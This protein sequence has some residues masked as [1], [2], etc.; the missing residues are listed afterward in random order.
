[1]SAL[2]RRAAAALALALVAGLALVIAAP[3]VARADPIPVPSVPGC[4]TGDDCTQSP[5][6]TR[7]TWTA[8]PYL[9]P[10]PINPS[11]TPLPRPSGHPIPVPSV[12]PE[13]KHP[14][15]EPSETVTPTP[16]PSATVTPTPE[17]AETATAT[18]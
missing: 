10:K 3:M 11:A 6:I 12:T 14:T 5:T 7:H 15:P 16:E 9:T 18:P 4:S 17:P 13:C 1:M 8:R 2:I